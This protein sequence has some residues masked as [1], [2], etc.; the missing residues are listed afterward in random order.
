MESL[1]A[2]YNAAAKADEIYLREKE[3]LH[4]GEILSRGVLLEDSLVNVRV[5]ESQT[6]AGAKIRLATWQAAWAES[7]LFAEYVGLPA[8]PGADFHAATNLV[9]QIL[10]PSQG[11]LVK[12]LDQKMDSSFLVR[13]K[14]SGRV[15]DNPYAEEAWF[16]MI[17]DRPFANWSHPSRFAFVA[18]DLSSCVVLYADEPEVVCSGTEK[19]RLPELMRSVDSG[20]GSATISQ[21]KSFLNNAFTSDNALSYDGDTSHSY[22]VIISGGGDIESNFSRYWG[23]V[24]MIYSTLRKKYAMP[25]ENIRVCVS[26]GKSNENDM[27]VS[28]GDGGWGDAGYYNSPH[29]LDGDGV[30]DVEYDSKK[31]TIKNVFA[32]LASKLTSEDRLFVFVTDHGSYDKSSGTC[33]LVPWITDSYSTQS[34]YYS[35]MISA[36]EF[37]SMV[38]G[39]KCPISFAFEFCYSGGFIQ[40]LVAQQ[41]R[42]VATA[43]GV[44]PSNAFVWCDPWNEDYGKKCLVARS[45][46]AIRGRGP[47]IRQ[48]GDVIRSGRSPGVT[49]AQARS[50]TPTATATGW[51][52]CTRRACSRRTGC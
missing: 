1:P 38:R 6:D 17:D 50:E 22:A 14:F 4:G 27:Q 26:D 48:S 29:D 35:L 31:S 34:Q 33:Y 51:S 44:E 9:R 5:L 21:I 30:D 13:G 3:R 42:V 15:F 45:I 41:N 18:K 36:S 10:L 24:A 19:V 39:I 16:F 25:K 32:S 7:P 52:A 2:D 12:G 49:T 28:I 43:C 23:D 40:P 47:S 20:R 8:L 46:A 37:A 11:W